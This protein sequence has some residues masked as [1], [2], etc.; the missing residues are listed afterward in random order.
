MNVHFCDG[1]EEMHLIKKLAEYCDKILNLKMAKLNEEYFYQG[2]PLCVIDAVYSIGV[3]Y[4]GTRNTVIRYCDFYGLQRIRNDRNSL[5]ETEDQ[6]SLEE[7]IEKIES[8]GIEFFLGNVFNNRQRTSSRSGILKCEAVLLMAKCL[9][10][11][12]VKYFQDIYKIIDDERFEKEVL[13]IPGQGSG[14]SLSYFLMLSG[15][16]D[17]IKP[18]RWIINFVSRALHLPCSQSCAQ[19]LLPRACNILKQKYPN[20]TP[21][22]LDNTIWKSQRDRPN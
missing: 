14:I 7:F 15:S 4:E 11:Y 18:D 3:K 5:P 13:S 10:R 2:L 21:R 20:L 22:L 8:L 6:E 17:L 1:N 9:Y 19:R 16:D 12:G